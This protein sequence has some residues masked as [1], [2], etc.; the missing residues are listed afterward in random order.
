MGVSAS[1]LLLADASNQFRGGHCG[2]KSPI[3]LFERISDQNFSSIIMLFNQ[4]TVETRT[5]QSRNVSYWV[6]QVCLLS[7]WPQD[8]LNICEP[9][10]C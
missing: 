2:Q 3:K 4:P 10:I 8:I 6:S 7:I 9:K 5:E 1:T